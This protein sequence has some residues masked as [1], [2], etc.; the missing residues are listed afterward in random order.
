MGLGAALIRGVALIRSAALVQE[1]TVPVRICR[2]QLAWVGA[3][4]LEFRWRQCPG[5][6]M[7]MAVCLNELGRSIYLN[8]S[9]KSPSKWIDC[10]DDGLGCEK[11]RKETVE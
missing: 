11:V 4:A 3:S 5:A 9:L 6:K 10:V 2:D 7:Q 1:F 8:S